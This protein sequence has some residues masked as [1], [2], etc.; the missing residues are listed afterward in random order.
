MK[1]KWGLHEMSGAGVFYMF[2]QN[3]VFGSPSS[4]YDLNDQDP[5]SPHKQ[6]FSYSYPM[7]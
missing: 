5:V 6:S 4:V 1:L 3:F 7:V 2:E